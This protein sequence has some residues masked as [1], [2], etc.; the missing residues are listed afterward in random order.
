[1]QMPSDYDCTAAGVNG[2]AIT[3]VVARETTNGD[4]TFEVGLADAAFSKSRLMVRGRS[5]VAEIP[6]G[7]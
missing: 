5:F 2:G 6:I 1:M 3:A 4:V 7:V